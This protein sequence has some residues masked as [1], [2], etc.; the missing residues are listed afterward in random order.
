[1]RSE[2]NGNQEEK[3]LVNNRPQTPPQSP[4]R[5]PNK[6]TY[7]NVKRKFPL[8]FLNNYLFLSEAKIDNRG[9]LLRRRKV[10]AKDEVEPAA[11]PRGRAMSIFQERRNSDTTHKEFSSQCPS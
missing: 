6:K 1:M 11:K 10:G 2:I 4:I 5:I 3:Q 9:T 8:V 7:N